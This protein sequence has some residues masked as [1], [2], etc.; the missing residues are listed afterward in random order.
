MYVFNAQWLI[1]EKATLYDNLV[2]CACT[3]VYSSIKVEMRYA[4]KILSYLHSL[5]IILQLV[6]PIQ[7]EIKISKLKH[8][9][10]MNCINAYILILLLTDLTF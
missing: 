5:S 9:C 10:K 2:L 6:L 4:S 1:T 3:N 8:S 7:E